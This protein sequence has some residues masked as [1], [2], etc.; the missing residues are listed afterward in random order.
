MTAP[1]LEVARKSTLLPA[2][3]W[4]L[5]AQAPQSL[6]ARGFHVAPQSTRASTPVRAMVV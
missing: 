2:G 5:A 6:S 4:K 3:T 1:V